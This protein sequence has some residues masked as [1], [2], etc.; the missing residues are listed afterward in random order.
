VTSGARLLERR[1]EL[2]PWALAAAFA[3]SAAVLWIEK[4]QL[5]DQRGMLL[6]DLTALEQKSNAERER[7]QRELATLR[8]KPR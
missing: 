8:A 7:F 2:L 1:Q 5:A 3:L 4:R 6:R